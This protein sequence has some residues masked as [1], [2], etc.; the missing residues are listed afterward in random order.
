MILDA[1]LRP[2]LK[3]AVNLAVRAKQKVE[4]PA[5]VTPGVCALATCGKPFQ[6]K[7]HARKQSYC[8]RVCYRKGTY[9][10]QKAAKAEAVEEVGQCAC[11][12]CSNDVLLG[13]GRRFCSRRCAGR[14]QYRRRAAQ[15][16]MVA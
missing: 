4:G 10:A 14:D 3:H 1:E 13:G 15:G 7:P 9:L 12:D 5:V 8:S 11:D 16:R 2:A 6:M